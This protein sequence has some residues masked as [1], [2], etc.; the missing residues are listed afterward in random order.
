MC[1]LKDKEFFHCEIEVV[2]FYALQQFKS[3]WGS[4]K[5]AWSAA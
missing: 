3:I 2:F 1:S 5:V 4:D